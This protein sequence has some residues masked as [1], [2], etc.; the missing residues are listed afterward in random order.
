MEASSPINYVMWQ[1]RVSRSL[2]PEQERMLALSRDEIKVHLTS[3]GEASGS[4]EVDRAFMKMADG[5][6]LRQF[7][8]LGYSC[9]AERLR[10]EA[11]RLEAGIKVQRTIIL[12]AGDHRVQD[13]IADMERRL[14]LVREDIATAERGLTQLSEK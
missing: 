10:A 12:P 2:S 6:S 1:G 13:L 7:L 3:S 4:E 11:S 5:M 8:Q 14:A 9:R